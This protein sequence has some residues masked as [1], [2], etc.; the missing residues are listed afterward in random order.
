MKTVAAIS[1]IPVSEAENT[2][3]EGP[4]EESHAESV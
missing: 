4:R 2:V 1:Q 3:L